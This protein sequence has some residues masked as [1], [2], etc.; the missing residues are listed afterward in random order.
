MSTLKALLKD[1]PVEWKALI[2]LATLGTGSHDTKDAVDNG[3]YVFYARGIKP[4]RLNTYD[5]DE[6]AIITAGDG[7]GVGKVF[8]WVE[9]KYALHQRAY[10]IVPNKLTLP[11][12]IYHYFVSNFYDYISKQSV[13]SSVSSLR[14]PMFEKFQIPIPYPNDPEKSLAVQQ[15][16]VRV[17]DGL[18]EQNKAL[19][20]ALAQEIDQR[21][22]QYAYYREE[23]FRFEGKE[24][25]WKTLGEV[26][27]RTKGT[28]ITAG[29]MKELDKVGGNIKIFAGGKTVAFFNKEDLPA[30]DINTLPSIIVKSRGIIEFE[31]Y[32]KPFSHKNEMW[33]YNT[34]NNL[35]KIKYV[36]HFLK[37]KEPYFQNLGSR[38][39]MPQISI[40]DTDKFKIPI[41]PVQEQERI[42]RLLDRFDEATKNIV[43]QLEREI[44][45]RN[46]QYEY[47]RNELLGFNG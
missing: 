12:F 33:S 4:L 26:L 14:K 39:Q 24:V 37:I 40:P 11:R 42:V 38:M 10:R 3:N 45:L 22:K 18:S 8:H 47:Y 35:I 41:I 20:T 34:A 36:Y 16:I 9:G 28:K 44:E 43:A 25:E 19:T 46:K 7:V 15:E 5:F 21:K 30:K 23:L 2:D 13:F 27:N 29:Q 31:Y 6:T 1:V 17:L 32:D